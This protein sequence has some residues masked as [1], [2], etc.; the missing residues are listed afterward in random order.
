MSGNETLEVPRGSHMK[1]G[2]GLLALEANKNAGGMTLYLGRP[3]KTTRL[4]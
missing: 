3:Y 4:M 1:Q 2:S